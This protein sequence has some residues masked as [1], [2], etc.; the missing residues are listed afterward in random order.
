MQRTYPGALA[1]ADDDAVGDINVVGIVGDTWG[2]LLWL[3]WWGTGV[4]IL[5]PE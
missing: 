3:Y 4:L 2:M 5:W 1:V